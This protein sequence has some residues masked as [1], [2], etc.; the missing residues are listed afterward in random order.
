MGLKGIRK[1]VGL[2]LVFSCLFSMSGCWDRT[3][4]EEIAFALGVAVDFPKETKSKDIE[5]APVKKVNP[6]IDAPDIAVSPGE[7][8]GTVSLV[9]VEYLITVELPNLRALSSG[10]SG[11]A[12][13]GGSKPRRLA[14]VVAASMQRAVTALSERVYRPLFFG[15]QRVLIIGEEVAR[16]GIK[17]IIDYFLRNLRINPRMRFMI[18]KGEAKKVLDIEPQMDP[19][20]SRYLFKLLQNAPN[21]SF[22]VD[23]N[24]LEL[25]NQLMVSGDAVVSRVTAGKDDATVGG[26]AVIR[27]WKL[28]GWLGEVE[29]Q[30]FCLAK[31]LARQG[32]I[33]VPIPDYPSEELAY[34]YRNAK[35]K[36]VPIVTEEEVSFQI[37]V[38]LRG[39]ITQETGYLALSKEQLEWAERALAAEVS[40]RVKAGIDKL[41]EFKVDACEFGRAVERAN[42]HLWE[43]K[44]RSQW[45]EIYPHVNVE[46]N[47]VVTIL[48]SGVL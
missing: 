19:L 11:T 8:E 16:H 3:E 33:G 28:V 14:S 46:V 38:D 1:A 42:Y 43:T 37:L 40:R 27:D 24:L 4:I 47:S 22:G 34:Y 12:A 6:N 15:H 9:P 10:Q 25:T 32:T 13:G 7:R 30:G 17:P 21:H 44:Y 23:S 39:G 29:T 36:I 26:S 2:L 18:S 48:S 35:S 20:T 31:G 5:E 41:Q 45:E